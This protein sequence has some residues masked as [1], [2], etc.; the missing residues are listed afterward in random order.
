MKY[1]NIDQVIDQ[2]S[3]VVVK[4]N[5]LDEVKK[6][7]HA[8]GELTVLINFT[9]LGGCITQTI[10]DGTISIH[11]GEVGTAQLREFIDSDSFVRMMSGEV[12]PPELAMTGKVKFEGEFLR[13]FMLQPLLPHLVQAYRETV[14]AGSGP[15]R[16]QQ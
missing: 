2:M 1:E 10:A 5:A 4:L 14:A 9:D 6:L 3:E 16:G 7:L 15:P 11:G 8:I 12:L 13:V